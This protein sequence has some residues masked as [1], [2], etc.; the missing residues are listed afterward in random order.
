MLILIQNTNTMKSFLTFAALNFLAIDTVSAVNIPPTLTGTKTQSVSISGLSTQAEVLKSALNQRAQEEAAKITID[1]SALQQFITQSASGLGWTAEQIAEEV[2]KVVEDAG[3]KLQQEAP[4]MVTDLVNKI[5]AK[6][7]SAVSTLDPK[8]KFQADYKY[9]EDKPDENE[10][11]GGA[12]NVEGQATGIKVDVSGQVSFQAGVSVAATATADFKLTLGIKGSLDLDGF[13]PV[14]PTS[15]TGRSITI[16]ATPKWKNN[17]GASVGV[18]A[19]FGLNVAA[20]VPGNGTL[21]DVEATL[22]I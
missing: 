22:S 19:F 7:S 3:N 15:G 8:A 12:C 1:T 13:N 14:R 11:S 5:G 6:I 2:N 21:S 17:K 20:E 16:K 18:L 4:K 10:W 9:R